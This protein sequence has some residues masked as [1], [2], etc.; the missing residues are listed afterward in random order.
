MTV[1]S[2]NTVC[3]NVPEIDY[4]KLLISKWNSK[5][6]ALKVEVTRKI[7][8]S[9]SPEEIKHALEK[10]GFKCNNRYCYFQI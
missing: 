8:V 7:H 5:T 3:I 1:L 4:Y 6:C 2:N 9:M 10:I